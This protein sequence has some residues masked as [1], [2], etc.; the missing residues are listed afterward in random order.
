LRIIQEWLKNKKKD[1]IPGAIVENLLQRSSFTELFIMQHLHDREKYKNKR[2]EKWELYTELLYIVDCQTEVEFIDWFL[3]ENHT[4]LKTKMKEKVENIIEVLIQLLP[5]KT[6]VSTQ[7][8]LNI[9]K[10]AVSA[11]LYRII[12]ELPKDEKFYLIL[13][14]EMISHY[15]TV[16]HIQGKGRCVLKKVQIFSTNIDCVSLFN[17][18]RKEQTENEYYHMLNNWLY[19]ASDSP[20]W[21]QRINKHKGEV[22]H[23]KKVVDFVHDDHIEE[24]YAYFSYDL[25]EEHP[26]FRPPHPESFTDNNKELREWFQGVDNIEYFM[27]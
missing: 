24:F 15:K 8:M 2:Y 25:D 18:K 9:S 11:Y 20:L 10:S 14:N 23:A 19:Y 1:W 16:I 4:K 26:D 17:F 12:L 21:T 13:D 3:T 22:D 27:L 5:N 7:Q 6:E